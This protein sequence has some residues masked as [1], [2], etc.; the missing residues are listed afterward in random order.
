MRGYAVGDARRAVGNSLNIRVRENS[1]DAAE[2]SEVVA[3]VDSGAMRLPAAAP[4]MTL[5]GYRA[6]RD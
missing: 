5:R 2:V 4:T 1:G 6:D 3:A